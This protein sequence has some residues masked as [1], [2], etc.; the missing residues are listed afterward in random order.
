MVTYVWRRQP[1]YIFKRSPEMVASLP[2]HDDPP[3]GPE[4]QGIRAARVRA[5]REPLAPRRHRGADR[6]PARTWAACRSS[7][8]S[9]GDAQLGAD[10][11]GGFLCPCHGSRF[12]LAGRVFNGSPAST[13]LRIPPYSFPNPTTLVIGHDEASAK[14]EA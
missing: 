4:V 7:A 6:A 2:S 11:P 10:W 1:I 12:D 3:Q 5:E 8:S 13:N 14:E 9:K